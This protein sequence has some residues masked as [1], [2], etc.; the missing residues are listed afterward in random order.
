MKFAYSEISGV[1]SWERFV[2]PTLVIENQSFFRRLLKDIY[3]SLDGVT[4]PIT[5]S[6]EHRPLEFSKYAEIITDFINFN[7]NQKSLL[8][9]VCA[10]LERNSVSPE[11]YLETQTLLSDIEKKV[12]KWAFEFPCDIV[13]SK[14]SVINLIRAIG[15]E[16]NNDYQGES[17]DAERIIDYMELVREFDRDKMFITVNMRS[18]FSDG[19]I[20]N[21]MKTAASHE[22]KVFMIESKSYPLLASEKRL[23]IDEDL[24]EF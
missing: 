8:N 16:I 10:A 22:Y 2:I 6:E 12:G 20:E 18:Y 15:I 17:G 13:A 23:T 11:S 1:F 24:C 14:I 9:K 3:Q 21:F 4:T 5:L 19:V 7:I